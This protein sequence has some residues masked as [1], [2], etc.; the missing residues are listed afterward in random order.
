MDLSVLFES[1]L[2]SEISTAWSSFCQ[3]DSSKSRVNV[4]HH[5]SER[6]DLVDPRERLQDIV[7]E[8][9]ENLSVDDLIAALSLTKDQADYIELMTRSQ[10]HSPLWGR[11]KVYASHCVKFWTSLLCKPRV[12]LATTISSVHN[13][14]QVWVS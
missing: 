14:W 2:S 10:G 4:Q 9:G 8:K 7:K 1:L 6:P 11:C 13:T 12:G 3:I 5:P